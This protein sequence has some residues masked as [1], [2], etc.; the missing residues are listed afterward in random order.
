[1]EEYDLTISSADQLADDHIA[2]KNTIP[3]TSCAID[4]C[5]AVLTTFI[6]HVWIEIFVT[7]GCNARNVDVPIGIFI[8]CSKSFRDFSFRT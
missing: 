2:L 5:K 3:S 8:L 1:M 7:F 6:T 4:L